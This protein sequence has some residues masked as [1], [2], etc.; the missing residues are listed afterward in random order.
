MSNIVF[1][2]FYGEDVKGWL[3]RCFQFFKV[4]EVEDD[5]KVQL[6]SMHLYDK[7]LA[8]HQQFVELTSEDV[9]WE[10][11]QEV[12]LKRFGS[13]YDDPLLELKNLRQ[14]G[15]VQSYHDA[16][17]LPLCRIKLSGTQTVNLFI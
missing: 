3:Y 13:G 4:D 6:E 9:A 17:N 2:K 15:T 16:F 10:V 12:I 8:W 14:Q 5:Q 1:P 11:C 7:A